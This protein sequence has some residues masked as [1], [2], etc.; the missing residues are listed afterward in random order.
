M[1]TDKERL[2]YLQTLN[3]RRVYTGKVVCRE[4]TTG[5]GWRLHETSRL[6]G[7]ESVRAAIDVAMAESVDEI[8]KILQVRKGG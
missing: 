3:D 5:R 7:L 6:E 2:D 1:P 8:A 4:S